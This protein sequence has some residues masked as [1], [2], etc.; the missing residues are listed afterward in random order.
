MIRLG[1]ASLSFEMDSEELEALLQGPEIAGMWYNAL[2]KMRD[3]ANE[4]AAEHGHDD[5]EYGSAVH[6]DDNPWGFEAG[7]YIYTAN[8]KARIDDYYHATLLH[9]YSMAESLVEEAGRMDL[10]EGRTYDPSGRGSKVRGADGR[11]T[12]S[13]GVKA[14]HSP[15]SGDG[16]TRDSGSY[17]RGEARAWS[18]GPRSRGE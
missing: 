9:V 7:G 5:A 3:K 4:I 16:S 8:F 1:A 10:G 13:D 14:A 12:S 6:E 2:D 17:Q 18:D 11:Y 15:Y